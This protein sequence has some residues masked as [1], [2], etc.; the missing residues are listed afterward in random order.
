MNP[1]SFLGVELE[2]AAVTM[3]IFDISEDLLQFSG[4]F[5]MVLELNV[6]LTLLVHYKYYFIYIC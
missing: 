6:L 3:L 5:N 2:M 1:S 4:V